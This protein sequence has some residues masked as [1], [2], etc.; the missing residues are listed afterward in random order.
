MH[1][2]SVTPYLHLVVVG[3]LILVVV[4]TLVVKRARE[5]AR[6]RQADDER[7]SEPKRRHG[8]KND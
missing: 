3:A 1:D 6:D 2:T 7:G 4:V 8:A 5:R